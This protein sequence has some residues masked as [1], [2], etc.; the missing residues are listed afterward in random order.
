MRDEQIASF[1]IGPHLA[2]NVYAEGDFHYE[3]P[4]Y[5]YFELRQWG[6]IR[7]PRRRFMGIGPER[8][9]SQK[10]TL[11]RTPD[12]EVAALVLNGEVQMIHEFSSGYTWPGPYTNVTEP[13]WQIA[14][15]LL[16]RLRSE[17]PEVRC[18]R[19]DWYRRQL[20]RQHAK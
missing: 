6:E 7:V 17:H 19:Q 15:L 14:E 12:D 10:F 18:P 5:I 9:P 20:D 16:Q 4:G 3:P 13:Q 1:T 8:K 2:I 11:I